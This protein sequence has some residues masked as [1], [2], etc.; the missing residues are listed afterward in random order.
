MRRNPSRLALRTG[1]LALLLGLGWVGVATAQ[2]DLRAEIERASFLI[3]RGW[4]L[5]AQRP[6]REAQELLL[7]AETR[8]KEAED[9]ARRGE[10]ERACL[11]ARVSQQLAR[12]AAE[13]TR[14]GTEGVARLEE[15][16][17]RTDDFLEDSS[18]TVSNNPSEEAKKM[19]AAARRQQRNAWAAF[20]EQR[21]R[22]SLK[23]TLMARE[24]ARRAAYQGQGGEDAGRVELELGVTDRLIQEAER[25]REQGQNGEEPPLSLN[26]AKRFQA[27]A[28]VQW[29]D[30]RPGLALRLTRQARELVSRAL[31]TPDVAPLRRG[32]RSMI[33]TTSALIDRLLEDAVEGSQEQAVR[34]LTRAE[35]LLE[36]ARTAFSRGEL[37]RAVGSV[38]AAS[39]LA[40]DVSEMMEHGQEE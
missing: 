39:A 8:R 18:A 7:A 26:L 19:L 30:Q 28:W 37:R 25:T 4:E 15:M 35:S 16:L 32:I 27:Q 22:M 12:K 1:V 10:R 36:E 38:R 23:L 6:V 33:A 2:C 5:L 21:P 11:L 40:L 31:G 14:R 24:T 34:R 9:R 29:R 17:R 3:E 20:R 13:V